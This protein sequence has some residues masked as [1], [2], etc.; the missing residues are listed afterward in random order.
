MAT[1]TAMGIVMGI[2]TAIAMR[3]PTVRT[4]RISSRIT[5]STS[6]LGVLLSWVSFRA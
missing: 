1:V 2:V 3:I 5:V 4:A 6:D